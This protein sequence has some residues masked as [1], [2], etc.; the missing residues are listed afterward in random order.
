M[1]KKASLYALVLLT[2]LLFGS[3]VS[4][5]P[6]NSPPAVA[7]T[8]LPTA[9]APA[10]TATTASVS[11]DPTATASPT[12]TPVPAAANGNFSL[13]ILHTNDVHAHHAP[14]ADGDGYLEF[15]APFQC[16]L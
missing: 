13:T 8:A 11:V 12:A 7:P 9:V 2:C 1:N 5:T 3:L 6:Q 14:N 15:L 4:C 16:S 10:I